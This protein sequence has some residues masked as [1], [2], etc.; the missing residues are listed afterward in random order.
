MAIAI[1]NKIQY[2]QAR[3][4]SGPIGE[5]F[6]WWSDELKQLLP[7]SWQARLRLATRRL[8]LQFDAESMLL[9]LE[10]NHEVRSLESFPLE[11]DGEL[12]KKQVKALLDKDELNELPRFLALDSQRILVKELKLPIAAE[13][14]LQQVLSFEM[15]RQTPFR[16]SEVYFDWRNLPPGSE[17]GE[18]R[19]ELVVA[20]RKFVDPLL[21]NLTGRG[22]APAGIDVMQAGRTLGVNLLPAQLR[23]QSMNSRSRLNYGLAAATAL[24]LVAVMMQSLGARADRIEKLDQAIA[25][26]QDEARRVQKLKEQLDDTSEAASFLT[27]RRAESPLA[28]EIV[29]EVTTTLPDGTYLDRLVLGKDT[30]IMQG[31]SNN[32]QQLIELVNRSAMFAEAGFQGSTRLDNSSGL[33]IFEIAT[34]VSVE[35]SE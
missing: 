27:R 9:C 10:E 1:K 21:D 26:V 6:I 33:E 16:A 30:V 19:L 29:A 5:F 3:I 25:E 18:I 11:Q 17:P 28:V 23:Q 12:A 4:R 15:D 2:W 22:L 8:I 32:A 24:L 13:G 31:K 20:P 7:E 34:M 14:N 35:K